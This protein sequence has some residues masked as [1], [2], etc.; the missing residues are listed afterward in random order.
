MHTYQDTTTQDIWAFEDDVVVTGASPNI[1]F[2]SA[3]GAILNA[4]KTL[5]PYTAPVLT[6]DQIAA[7]Q[8]ASAKA[9]L[10]ASAQAALD[11]MDAPGGCAIRCFKAG[12]TFPADW[13]AYCVALRAIVNSTSTATALPT[14]PAYPAGT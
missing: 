1:V 9:A 12:V 7:Q 6:A 2:T 8:A 14:Q 5:V 10:V 13:L 4:P 3:L 11:K